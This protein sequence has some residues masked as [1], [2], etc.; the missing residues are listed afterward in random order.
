MNLSMGT[1]GSFG[2]SAQALGLTSQNLTGDYLLW[3]KPI[4]ISGTLSNPNYS[5]LSEIIQRAIR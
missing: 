3:K 2:E 1:K 4:N 5:A